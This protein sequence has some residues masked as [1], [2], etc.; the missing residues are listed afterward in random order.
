MPVDQN[1]VDNGLAGGGS[2]TQ[3]ITPPENAEVGVVHAQSNLRI[4]VFW[5]K[6]IQLWFKL[7]EAQ[8]VSSRI[9]K[10]DTKY[11]IAVAH[12]SEKYVE[13]V[14]DV[15]MDPPDTGKYEALKAALVKRLTDSDSS[16]VR[17]LLESEEIGDRKPSQ[18]FRDLKNLATSSIS[19]DFVLVL[20]KS[21]LPLETQRVLA[22]S[23]VTE[24]SALLEMAD[25][26]HEIPRNSGRIAAVSQNSDLDAL[27]SEIQELRKQISAVSFDRAQQGSRGRSKSRQNS[28]GNPNRGRSATPARCKKGDPEWLCYYHYRH[29]EN[30]ERCRQPCGWKGSSA[31]DKTPTGNGQ[32]RP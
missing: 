31:Y 17:K 22:V 24:T 30:A 8:F 20:W 15:I 9:V 5:P 11:N 23:S 4:P 1:G 25:S 21:R 16:R 18:F 7:L 10:D 13:Q 27:R 26:V 2:G 32:G 28:G 6:K 19:D 29:G 3:N 12:I 14:E